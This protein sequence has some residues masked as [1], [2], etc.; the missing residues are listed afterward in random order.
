MP[1]PFEQLKWP[2]QLH[3]ARPCQLPF[4]GLGNGLGLRVLGLAGAFCAEEFQ[5]RS[6]PSSPNLTIVRMIEMDP[7]GTAPI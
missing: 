3:E 6:V 4:S 2:E 1:S 7:S 5:R